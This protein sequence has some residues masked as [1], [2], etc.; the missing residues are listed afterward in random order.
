MNSNRSDEEV[1]F[2]GTTTSAAAGAA[3][4][5]QESIMDR[6][7]RAHEE[8]VTRRDGLSNPLTEPTKAH[9]EWD[10]E[11]IE[12]WTHEQYDEETNDMS[13]NKRPE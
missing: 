3:S 1:L 8:R 10:V 11:L 5:H 2:N 13:Q 6:L 12:D 7:R 9:D 4:P